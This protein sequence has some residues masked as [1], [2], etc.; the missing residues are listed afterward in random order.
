M[1]KFMYLYYYIKLPKLFNQY[2]KSVN[3]VHNYNTRNADRK[4]FQLH[5]GHSNTAKKALSFSGAQIWNNLNPEWRDFSH[6]RF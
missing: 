4:N 6:Y 1:T 3:S 2:F 5:L